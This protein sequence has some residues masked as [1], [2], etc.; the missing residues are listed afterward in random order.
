[1]HFELQITRRRLVPQRVEGKD[2]RLAGHL[3]NAN[4][5][6]LSAT[7]TW[8]RQ[9]EIFAAEIIWTNL[10]KNLLHTRLRLTTYIFSSALKNDSAQLKGSQAQVEGSQ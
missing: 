3:V 1:M 10:S 2:P 7:Q 5:G 8:T 6:Q 9:Q 4:V